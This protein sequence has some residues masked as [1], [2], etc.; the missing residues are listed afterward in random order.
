MPSSNG[1]DAL[2]SSGPAGALAAFAGKLFG[3]SRSAPPESASTAPH[4]STKDGWY[5]GVCN[6][7]MQGD[8]VTRVHM[9]DGVVVKVEGDPRAPNHRGT[10]CPRGNSAIMNLYNPWRVKAPVKRTNPKKGLDQDPGFVGISW[11]EALQ[12]VADR[13]KRVRQ[14]NPRKLVVISGFGQAGAY[15]SGLRPFMNAFQTPN[16]IPS[17]GSAC[18][19]HFGTAYT[20]GQHPDSVVDVGRCE[21]VI[22]LGRSQG[23][24]IAAA[25]SGTRSY[26]DA[27]ERGAKII[28]V[29]PRC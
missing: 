25:S 18:A 11:D 26:L 17:R 19:Y 28:T 6:M 16:D 7:S 2:K 22:N 12:T 13:L 23:P 24:N 29:D 5:P 14:G 20:Q 4:H 1:D 8:C 9:V 21:Y 10:L 3:A 27:L 15:H